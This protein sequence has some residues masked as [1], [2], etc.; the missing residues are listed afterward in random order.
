MDERSLRALHSRV[1][2]KLEDR[3]GMV[4]DFNPLLASLLGA[5]TNLLHL[6]SKEQSKGA[7]F[8]I[9]PYINKD[10]VK[11][12][13]ALPLLLQAHEHALTHASV[14]DDSGTNKR[15]AQ[16][17]LTR[18]L[19]KMNSMIEVSD[20]Q[21]AA[22]VLGL[23][24]SMCSESF[25]S[26]NAKAYE[27]HVME[28]IRQAGDQSGAGDVRNDQYPDSEE[29]SS[30]EDKFSALFGEEDSFID[31]EDESDDSFIG[32]EEADES[33]EEGADGVESDAFIS[34]ADNPD[35]SGKQ[36]ATTDV[37]CTSPVRQDEH[38]NNETEDDPT[39]I[40]SVS[41]E[42]GFD[43]IGTASETA[44]LYTMND[45]KRR[46]VRHGEVYRHRGKE[47]K[48]CSR[49]EYISIFRVQR[50]DD[51]FSSNRSGQHGFSGGLG[52]ESNY[53]QVVRSRLCTLK[54]MR[55]PPPLPGRMVDAP[56]DNKDDGRDHNKHREH[57]DWK[58]KADKFGCHSLVMFRPE[59]KLH[60]GGQKNMYTYD[61]DTFDKFLCEQNVR[62]GLWCNKARWRQVERIIH[63][64]RIDPAR[65]DMLAAYRARN[66]EV[67]TD[68]QKEANKMLYSRVAGASSGNNDGMDVVAA[69]SEFTLRQRTDSQ[70]HVRHSMELLDHFDRL[71]ARA[72][73]TQAH[74]GIGPTEE[75]GASSSGGGEGTATG[76]VATLPFDE[77]LSNSKR[78]ETMQSTGNEDD[79]A[80]SDEAKSHAMHQKRRK[81]STAT[82]KKVDGYIERQK[83]SPD[84]DV[85]VKIM[86]DHCE[87]M[88]EGRAE[89]NDYE[90]PFLLVCG[91]PGNGKSKLVETLDGMAERMSSGV[92]IKNAYMGSAA[93]NINGTTLLK[94]WDIP[95]FEDKQTKK[96]GRWDP[97]K[98]QKLK[99]LLGDDIHRICCIVLDE[100]STV[101]PYM[102]AC[103]NARLQEMFQNDKLWGGRAVVLLGDFDQKPPTAGGK[104]N[105]LPGSVMEPLERGIG[106]TTSESAR[107][108][109]ST[110]MG[111]WL[112]SKARYIKLTSQHRA[113]GDVAHT[114]TLNEMSEAG[115]ITVDHL[116]KYKQLSSED[117]AGGDFRFAT[118]IVTGNNERREISARQAERW[119]EHF[120]VFNVR[121]ARKRKEQSWKGR[122]QPEDNVTHALGCSLFW[123]LFIPGAKGYLNTYGINADIGL[124][125][126]TEIKY[127]SLS[128]EHQKDE[129][130]LMSK[131]NAARP[132]DT[133]TIEEPPTAINVELYAD[134][135]GDT[136]STKAEKEDARAAWLESGKGSITA[137][138]RVII[139]VSLRDGSPIP[140]KTEY[141]PGCNETGRWYRASQIKMKDHFPIEPAFAVTVDKAQVRSPFCMV[142]QR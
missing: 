138:G 36:E 78:E 97:T 21:G 127:H 69:A 114:A 96:L 79:N 27:R 141:I 128:F 45:G 54:Y 31:D 122:P 111:G 50:K 102:L 22:A 52:M 124:A 68:E 89:D 119:A 19:N 12:N 133:V 107:K 9:G 55:S 63:G 28:E 30:E 117:L 130:N 125:N 91:K 142:L 34:D 71:I 35:R 98:L 60:K 14:A 85:A 37:V 76:N 6:G 116:K 44:P 18:T 32:D 39:H 87:A 137:D 26:C 46:P 120:G 65:R 136:G 86:R 90:P 11:I 47:L 59:D 5:N 58:K 4:V 113:S 88:H 94:F 72:Q 70:K 99:T 7:L 17:V 123:E 140:Y 93:V 135:A 101:Q 20:T 24:A 118:M 105:T 43:F 132:G 15:F 73:G 129:R 115:R 83:L 74:N 10:G 112:L 56:S 8:Y 131:L 48:H 25:V 62:D 92:V 61:W 100:V 95:V 121:W 42:K 82:K 110:R 104:A 3:N 67:W 103:L 126:G 108:L 38:P 66:R 16:Q 49:Y 134:F 51:K 106:A 77:H 80:G 81:L 23:G 33:E 84:K 13:D 53:H 1:N 29:E 40:A 2:D 139:P 64:W 57:T 75:G 41:V 109:D